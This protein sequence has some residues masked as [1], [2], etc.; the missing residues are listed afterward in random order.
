MIADNADVSNFLTEKAN[1]Y[2]PSNRYSHP[3]RWFV[4]NFEYNALD[5]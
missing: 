2:L 4:V 1:D 3:T 5:A